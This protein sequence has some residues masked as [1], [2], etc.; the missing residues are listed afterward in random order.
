MNNKTAPK[1]Q[2]NQEQ[3]TTTEARHAQEL[4]PKEIIKFSIFRH[5][6]E[7]TVHWKN[8]K[9]MH[10]VMHH[11]PGTFRAI[12]LELLD[13]SMS[14]KEIRDFLN[15]MKIGRHAHGIGTAQLDLEENL[16]KA[17]KEEVLEERDG[18][19]H[20][21][22]GGR[23]IAEH[24]QRVIP[25]FM[26]WVFSP[27]T[28]S[29]F[30]LVAHVVL[31][32]LKLSIGFL[33]LSAGLI[34]DGIDNAVD[35]LSSFLVWLGIKYDKEK[36]VSVFILITMFVSV[37]GVALATFNKIIHPGP[38]K[39]GLIAFVISAMCG[40]LMLGL[41][42]YQYLVGKKRS[43]FAIMCQAVDSRNHFLTSLLV[44]GGIL[45][46]FF[47]QLWNAPWLFYADTVAS[48]I[49]GLMIL[50]GA[51]ELVQEMLKESE[52]GTEVS[53]FMKRAEERIREKM[54]L[55]WLAGQLQSESLTEEELKQ[56]FTTDFCEQTP[57]ILILSGMGYRP[58]SGEDLHRYLELFV[59][60][61]KLI[62]DEGRYWLIARS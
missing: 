25:A 52:E 18:Q 41:S 29:L 53:H 5:R 22:P 46:S 8:S 34:A 43:N 24:M 20:L 13:R 23:E 3:N 61:R 58:E 31:S 21:T 10:R 49:I 42:S 1:I 17:I 56:R 35:T 59:E 38:I 11:F 7:Q 36:L 19:Y 32:V 39:E 4:T 62:N 48:A 26:K 37:G 54:L 9:E 40:L 47:A 50:R 15:R 33:S 2:R 27:E 28:A 30:S 55:K 16:R 51:I 14:R 6:R 12:M 57:K 60:Q 44:C 45:L